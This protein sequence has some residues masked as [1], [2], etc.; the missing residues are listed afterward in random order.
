MQRV[1]REVTLQMEECYRPLGETERIVVGRVNAFIERGHLPEELVDESLFARVIELNAADTGQTHE[2]RMQTVL[3]AGMEWLDAVKGPGLNLL[4]VAGRTG[5]IVALTVVLRQVV[6]YHVE[7][8]LRE[9]DSPEAGRAWA[10]VAMTMIGPALTLIGAI[11]NECDGTAN[12]SSRLGRV[13]MA[14]ITMG[15]LIAAHLTG[16]SDKLL[17]AVVGGSIYTV[18]RGL[19]NVFIPLQDNAGSANAA[20]TGVATA[21][22]GA[23]QFFLAELGQLAPLSG[24]ARATAELGYSL[25]ADAIQGV[26]NGFGIVVD[27]VIS[28]LCKSS[29][30]LSP[31]PGWDSVFSDP[32]ALRQ[33]VLEVRAEVRRPTRTQL[34]DALLDIGALRLSAGHAIALVMGAVASLLSSSRVDDGDQGHIMSG[35]LA[36][37]AM[38]IYFPLV[39]GSAKRTDNTYTLQETV[40]P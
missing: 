23:A 18:A 17:P 5:L 27:D 2:S 29:H 13:C 26:L 24:A 40:V 37:M 21:A 6:A 36:L 19:A 16:A 33:M 32:E 11:R 28:I 7:Q 25:G 35:C 4:N 8:S 10:M 31:D 39:F 34:A 38:I 1:N 12:L 30:V 15:A 22:Y 14:S 3:Q 20:T 9:G